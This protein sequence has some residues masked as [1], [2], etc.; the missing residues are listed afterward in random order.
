MALKAN[1][2]S[3]SKQRKER[4]EEEEKEVGGGEQAVSKVWSDSKSN[5][6]KLL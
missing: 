1:E 6:V 3:E 5:R 2:G 4:V